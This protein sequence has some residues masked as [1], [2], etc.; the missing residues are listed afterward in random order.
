MVNQAV[1]AGIEKAAVCLSRQIQNPR[2]VYTGLCILSW[3][4]FYLGRQKY[5]FLGDGYVRA[6]DIVAG[7]IASE[8]TGSLHMLVLL[9]GWL[10]NWDDSGVSS[11]RFFSVFWGGP[12]V[13]LVCIWANSICSR[14][15]DKVTC[16]ALMIFIGPVQY[17]FGY[18]ETYA[19]LPVFSVGF[20]L[21]GI[22]ALRGD[23][24]PL[25]AT[26][27]FAAGS[28]MHILL[29]LFLPALLY[30]WAAF[31]Y[32]RFS[33]FREHRAVF[34]S[35]GG[36]GLLLLVYFVGKEYANVLL[37]LVPAPEQPYAL[38]SGWHAWEW[39]NAQVLSA[40]MG[41]PLLMLVALA[42]SRVLCRETRF[43]V[44]GALGMLA[45]LFAI[46]PMLGSRDWDILCLSGV[47]LMALA[48]WG[49]YN[50]GLD[51]PLVNYASVLSVVLAALLIAP[52][53]HI[54]HTDRSIAR[55]KQILERDPGSYYVNHPV[56]STL[57]SYFSK[58]GLHSQAV[59]QWRKGIKKYPS[60]PQM[61]H[62]LG[63]EYLLQENLEKAVPNLLRALDLFPDY[64]PALRAMIFVHSNYPESITS[65]EN[66]FFSQHAD[67]SAAEKEI[68]E[69]WN[70]LGH[71]EMEKK[72]YDIAIQIFRSASRLGS[73]KAFF[74]HRLGI[75]YFGSGDL[76]NA[77]SSLEESHQLAPEDEQILLHLE[78][79][80]ESRNGA[81]SGEQPVRHSTTTNPGTAK[82]E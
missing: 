5:G 6:S 2:L 36:G 66:Y 78:Q 59:E 15:F 34:L 53:V 31:L 32:P 55:V 52:W 35:A 50:G 27:F 62:N 10:G 14:Q 51:R 63:Y 67:S 23:R 42:G 71:Q 61:P 9:Q 45:G 58:A 29:V 79:L 65:I 69:L 57:G 72:N 30:L 21:S 39:I 56:E 77:I 48:T 74:L 68:A 43:L 25:W 16:A 11:L 8:G 41:W 73:H 3:I 4:I 33:L 81:G 82:T 54:N 47:P 19:P 7:R 64:K 46:D 70:R 18:I 28:F 40:P 38:L 26:L 17:F 24:P 75:A 76:E 13:V 49:V 80:R 37:P 12:Y 44:A 1:G 22:T 60:N 20:L